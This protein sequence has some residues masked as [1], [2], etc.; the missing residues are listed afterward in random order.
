MS[1]FFLMTIIKPKQ[2]K[3]WYI[4]WHT[5]FF[6]SYSVWC[7][8][9]LS[10]RPKSLVNFVLQHGSDPHHISAVFIQMKDWMVCV[11]LVCWFVK[12]MIFLRMMP[13]AYFLNVRVG[14]LNFTSSNSNL[15]RWANYLS[16]KCSFLS[17]VSLCV[18]E[19]A[20]TLPSGLC[21]TY[22]GFVALVLFLIAFAAVGFLN[23]PHCTV[24]PTVST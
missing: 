10:K 7:L 19:H 17:D 16:M 18:C 9:I 21:V 13:L 24:H 14:Q 3:W 1:C 23:F 12:D 20:S 2:T 22:H 4:I 6:M 11:N 8:Y 5:F 15:A